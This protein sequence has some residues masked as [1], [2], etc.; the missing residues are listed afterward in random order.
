MRQGLVATA[1]LG[2]G[3]LASPQFHEWVKRKQEDESSNYLYMPIPPKD[4]AEEAA[5]IRRRR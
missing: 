1:A 2:L 3:I 5:P 4:D